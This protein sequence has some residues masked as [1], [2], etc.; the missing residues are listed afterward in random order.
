M[1]VAGGIAGLCEIIRPAVCGVVIAVIAPSYTEV[2]VPEI[3]IEPPGMILALDVDAFSGI[4]YIGLAK[5]DPFHFSWRD[6]PG[7][8]FKFRDYPWEGIQLAEYKLL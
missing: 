3:R 7:F 8:G 2:L 6:F 4:F 1:R 5:A